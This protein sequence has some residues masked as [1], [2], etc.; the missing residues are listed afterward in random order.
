MTIIDHHVTAKPS[1]KRVNDFL[2]AINHSGSVLAWQYFHPGEKV[3]MLFRYVEE[4][5]IWKWK[6]P[7]TRE[8]LMLL[9]L[10]PFEFEAWSHMA[11]EFDDAKL[12]AADIKKGA[13]L[14]VHYRSLYE[15]LLPNADLVKFAGRKIYALNCPRY[16]A[17][18]L[19]HEL[20]AKT[21]SIAL[22]WTETGGRVL[23]SLRSEGDIDVS[24][25]AM[26]YGGGGH[27]RSSGFTFDAKKKK[28]WELL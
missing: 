15:K 26:K 4:R 3:P 18:D 9:D 23:V 12:R 25:I 1:L 27:K 28:P 24:K 8:M 13:L 7:H 2:Y 22:L 17:D 5:D 20:V 6:L 19:G 14:L 21:H 10:A 11:R 16:F